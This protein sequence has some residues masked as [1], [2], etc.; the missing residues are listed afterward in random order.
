MSEKLDGVRCFW[1]GSQLYTRNGVK[2]KAPKEWIAKL[3]KI[4]LDGEMWTG[5]DEFHKCVTIT[6]H[7]EHDWEDWKAVKYMVFD[8]PMVK[9]TFAERIKFA[10]E[11]CGSNDIV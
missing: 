10:K 6:I 5:R 11:A 4:A 3:P 8:A 1:S 9:G 7:R 2:I